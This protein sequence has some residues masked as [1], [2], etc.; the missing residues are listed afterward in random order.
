MFYSI[1]EAALLLGVHPQPLEGGIKM[2][3]LSV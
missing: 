3:K 2:E 1:S